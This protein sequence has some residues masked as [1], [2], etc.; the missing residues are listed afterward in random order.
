MLRKV[1]EAWIQ[2]LLLW[3]WKQPLRC[4]QHLPHRLLFVF[5]F[6]LKN[7]RQWNVL[8]LMTKEPSQ[9]K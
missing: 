2:T 4:E 7:F 3:C 9:D 1:V 8:V 5:Y 6:L